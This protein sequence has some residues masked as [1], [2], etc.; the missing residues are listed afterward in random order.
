MAE[1]SVRKLAILAM[2]AAPDARGAPSAPVVGA[3]RLQKLIFLLDRSM[4]KISGDR[5]I[6]VDLAFEPQ[7]FG[8]ADVRIYQ[9]LEF[10]EALHH[11]RRTPIGPSGERPGPEESTE[12]ALSFG[13]LMGDE[14]E[15]GLL[16]EAE[17]ETFQYSI[18]ETGLQ[19]LNR[20]VAST[21][22]R[23]RKTCDEV[24]SK[25]A[26]TKAMYGSWPLQRLLR[27]VYSR[28]PEMTTASEIRERVLGR[29]Q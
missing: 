25:A 10:L 14:E 27:E 6:K 4:P 19:L 21:D 1:I 28:F 2:L 3:T 26:E 11:I 7:R 20:L 23:S 16:A 22:G 17:D 18:T 8:P 12:R 29:A 5:L 9:D 15:A 24:L 13:Y